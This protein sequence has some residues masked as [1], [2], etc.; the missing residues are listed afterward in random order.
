MD[1]RGRDYY[2]ADWGVGVTA[3]L[4]CPK[5]VCAGMVCGLVWTTAPVCDTQ[6]HYS[7]DVDLWHY[8]SANFTFT[9]QYC[10]FTVKS[11]LITSFIILMMTMTMMTML[12]MMMIIIIINCKAFTFIRFYYCY[13][14]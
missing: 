1:Y 4:Q 3:W 2:I 12:M 11:T 7:L 10:I 8:I 13:L 6:H 5:S 9:L 14:M